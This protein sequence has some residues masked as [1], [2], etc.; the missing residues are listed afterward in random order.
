MLITMS[1]EIQCR[2]WLARMAGRWTLLDLV[3]LVP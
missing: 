2:M 1:A 3:A